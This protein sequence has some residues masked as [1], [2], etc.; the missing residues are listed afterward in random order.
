MTRSSCASASA[1]S[2]AAR[3]TRIAPASCARPTSS[4]PTRPPRFSNG[5]GKGIIRESIRGFDLYFITDVG[6]CGISYTR[7]GKLSSMTPD[8]HYQDLKRLIAATRGLGYRMNVIMPLLYESR[9]HKI[10]GRESLDCAMSLQELIFLGVQNIM[11]IDAHN[12]HVQNAIPNHGFENLHANYQQIKAIL[13][14]ESD[15]RIGDEHLVVASPDLGGLERCR[16]FSEQFHT[17]LAVFYKHRDLSRIVNGRSPITEFRFMGGEVKGKDVVII[18]DLLASG[19]TALRVCRELKAMGARKN[20]IMCTFALFTDGVARFSEA[21]AD[22]VFN[23]VYATNGTYVPPEALKCE[24]YHT[25]DTSRFIALYIDS[26]N[27]N[28]SVSRLLDNTVKIRALLEQKG[29]L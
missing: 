9:Q 10:A 14:T 28:E 16:Y 23:R 22:G 21:F 20:Y 24:W 3:V 27:R 1:C 13:S 17:E 8:E 7:N 19:D 6:N 11:T 26:F 4:R 2:N 25:V 5:E 18:D 29:L 15:F 12:S